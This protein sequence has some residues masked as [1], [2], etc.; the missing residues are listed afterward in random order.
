ML[1]CTTDEDQ[2]D[3]TLKTQDTI[4]EKSGWRVPCDNSSPR[5]SFTQQVEDSEMDKS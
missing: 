3:M 1:V 2:I 4:E 5:R